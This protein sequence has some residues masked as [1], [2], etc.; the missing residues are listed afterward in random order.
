VAGELFTEVM[1][2][3]DEWRAMVVVFRYVRKKDVRFVDGDDA[4][5]YGQDDP[6]IEFRH[7]FG[8][9]GEV[10]HGTVEHLFGASDMEAKVAPTAVAELLSEVETAVLAVGVRPEMEDR[11]FGGVVETGD[12]L[13]EP[14]PAIGLSGQHVNAAGRADDV[15]ATEAPAL[16]PDAL[17]L[18][19]D[20]G[21]DAIIIARQDG[22]G[23]LILLQRLHVFSPCSD[24]FGRYKT[25]D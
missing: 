19:F 7:M 1:A 10:I 3:M 18:L 21:V 14:F 25:K 9:S 2:V 22:M 8:R 15:F 11:G 13:V 17:D 12:H 5:I 24:W 6:H 4:L 20:H 16:I 23:D